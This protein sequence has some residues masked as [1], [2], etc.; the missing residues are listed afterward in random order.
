MK[1]S[2][3][4]SVL[5]I[6]VGS[7]VLLAACASGSAPATGPAGPVGSAGPVGPAGSVGPA[8]QS[9]VVPG[10]GLKV[11]ITGAEFPATGKPVVSLTV[12]D[13]DGRPLPAKAIEGYG[14]TI[15]QIV[16][17]DT[18]H[19]SKYQNL[20]LHQVKGIP[21][22]LNG[23]VKQPALAQGMQP[24]GD[25]GGAWTGD[26]G[27]YTYTFSNT[28]TGSVVP[29]LTTSIGLYAYKDARAT[30]ANDVYTFVPAGGQPTVT[31]E[32]VT[33]QACETCHNPV[34][35]HGGVR[36]MTALCVTCHTDQ[37]IDTESGNSV[38]FKVMIH[39]I[40]SGANLPSVKAGTPYFIAGR[41]ATDFSKVVWPQDTRNCTTCH[42]GG[43]DSDHY[44][45][46][47][48]TAA[49][50]ACHDN[51]NL[52]TG[53]N[54]QGGVQPDTK[55]AG[56]HQPDDGQ[57]FSASI[58]GGHVIPANS[59]SVK[60]ITLQIVS[61]TN[62]APDASPV[63][64]FKVTDS[65]GAVIVPNTMPRLSANLAGPTTDYTNR[66]TESMTATAVEVG[67]GTYAYTFTAK[68]PKD[69]TGTYAL[70]LEGGVLQQINKV[71]VR[72]AAFNPVTYTAVSGSKLTPRRQIIDRNKCNA[73]HANLAPHGTYRQN[74][75]YCV[76]CHNPT[77]SDAANRP[78]DAMPPTSINFRVMI[79]R[80]HSGG[81]IA[82]PLVVYGGGG[83][84]TSFSDVVFPGNLADC[85]TCH[86]P[87]TYGVPLADNVLPTTVTQSPTV[88]LS[89]LPTRSV[90]TACHDAK[91]AIGHTELQTTSSGIETCEVCHGPG[92]E[93]DVTKVHHQ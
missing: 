48:N 11:K 3:L 18:T 90:C 30:V 32:I 53:E 50:T 24:F 87:N 29:T 44:K 9:F 6:V 74:T 8:G 22:T 65:T 61:F 78:A 36:Q 63:V 59:K 12:T 60:A 75:D 39:R 45:T 57:E 27:Q 37:N 15:A 26:N 2:T 40:H 10:A 19:L 42:S 25:T 58:I 83:T 92:A 67:G 70:G 80:L 17:D 62:V 77:A 82:N 85:Q 33:N 56:C 47:P 16:V 31:R 13:G 5:L 46:A 91:E 7:A 20:L 54:H 68:L 51:V 35:A 66:W 73:C 89:T 64:Q 81:S 88:V 72:I 4:F 1:R 14:F 93:F 55:C 71:A 43:A 34:Q 69:I 49:C 79:H 76:M 52:A 41:S 21:Y 23:V 28:L 84:P 38:E 86:L